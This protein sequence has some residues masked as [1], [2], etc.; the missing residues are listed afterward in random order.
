MDTLESLSHSLWE[1][2]Y[3][4]VF[5]PKCRRKTLYGTLR[6]HFGEVFPKLA[7]QKQSRVEEGHVRLEPCAHADRDSAEVCGLAG[8]RVHQREERDSRPNF[9]GQHFG[10]VATSSRPLVGTSA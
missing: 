1:C 4:V 5:V 2:K 9:V 6:R 3:H 8:D 7:A 10:R